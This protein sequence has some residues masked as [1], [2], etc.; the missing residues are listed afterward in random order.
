MSDFCKILIIDDEFIMRQGLKHMI[1]WEKEGFQIVGEAANGKEGLEMIE[2]LHPHIVLCDIVMPVMDGVDFSKVVQITYPEIQII[3]LSG[4]DNFEYVKGALL[5]GVADYVL[6]PTLKPAELLN[7]IRKSA[8]RIPGVRLKK[9][10]DA[11]LEKTL[12][13]YMLG[14]DTELN[15]GDI[16]SHFLHTFYRVYAVN[17][18]KCNEKG[19][20]LSPLFYEKIERYLETLEYC[21]Y[22]IAFVREELVCVILNYSARHRTDIEQAMYQMAEQLKLIYPRVFSVLSKGFSKLTDLKK[23]YENEIVPV[24]DRAFYY[25]DEHL[26]ILDET[27][28]QKAKIKKFD[29]NKYTN[30]LSSKRFAEA[31]ELLQKYLNEAL[32]AQTDE[33]R[34]KNQVKN[35]LYNF[36]DALDAKQET[37]DNMRYNFF[38]LID[39]AFYV[40]ECR[41]AFDHIDQKLTEFLKADSEGNDIRIR[42][43][44]DYIAENYCENLDLAEIAEVFSFNYY[45]LSTYFNQHMEEGFSEYLNRIR[46]EH[47]CRMLE[48]NRYTIAQISGAV[49]YSDHSYFCRVF[50]KITGE[51][52]SAWRRESR[53][54]DL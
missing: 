12:E 14:F 28:T 51:T 11:G 54:R 29:Y 21:C 20:D 31:L 45:Y 37:K 34:V 23:I 13:R 53:L 9:E 26:R 22:K 6:K 47:A 27:I 17:I 3:I 16:N 43:I 18:K 1:E 35:M 41:E 40:E 42:R 38:G 50:K 46:V 19:Q 4:Y 7:T 25:K 8:E 44:L 49:G 39:H 15:T 5:S 32:D 48:D 30:Y 33:Y 10:Q 2:N 36:L 52:P 24:V